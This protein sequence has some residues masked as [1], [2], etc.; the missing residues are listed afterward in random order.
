MVR[1]VERVAQT[2]QEISLATRE[3]NA[4]IGAVTQAVSQID[5]MTQQNAA[6]VEQS[7]AA[8]ESLRGQATRLTAALG[9]FRLQS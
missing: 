2:I 7:S 9:V 8:A 5:Q 3:Q 6:L 1:E 4:G